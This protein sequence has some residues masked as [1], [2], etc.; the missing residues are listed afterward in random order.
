MP[1]RKAHWNATYSGTPTDQLGWY[2]EAPGPSLDLIT[3]LNLPASAHI[4]DAGSGATTL[5]DALLDKGHTNLTAVDISRVALERLQTRLNPQQAAQVQWVV[6]DLTDAGT[7][8]TVEPVDLWHDRAVLHFLTDADDRAAYV[9]G[10]QSTVRP[11]GH[12]IIAAFARDGA[13]RC[14]GLDV[15]NYD[16]A[17]I[18]DLLGLEFKMERSLNHTYHQP[19]GSPRPYVYTRFRRT[20]AG[21]DAS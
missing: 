14:S 11:G 10:L 9:Q 20:E 7:L 2:E 13:E 6:G 16:A 1:T 15:R 18:D 5:I 8:A 19:S 21:A 12:V 17:M 3:E 4:L